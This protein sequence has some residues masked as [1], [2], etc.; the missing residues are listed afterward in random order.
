MFVR[1]VL[2]HLIACRHATRLI[3]V[4]EEKPLGALDR[5][6]LKLHLGW[7]LACRRFERQV[8]FLR[9]ALAKFGD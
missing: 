2:G 3:S 9:R 8:R 1:K 5:W 6:L 7:C 4:R